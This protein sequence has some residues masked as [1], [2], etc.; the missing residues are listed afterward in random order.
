MHMGKMLQWIIAVPLA[1][2]LAACSDEP[3][4]LRDAAP[5]P[6]RGVSTNPDT[7]E[8]RWIPGQYVIVFKHHEVRNVPALARSLASA[9]TDSILYVYQHTIKGFAARLAPAAAEA[10]KRHPLVESVLQD[11]LGT[12]DQMAWSWGH[13]R[14]DQ[15]D[16]PLNGVYAPNRTGAGV[17]IYILDTGI[18]RTHIDFG[19]RA[20][21]GYS[22]INDGRGS[23]D[24]N[25]HGTHVAGT[26][27]ATSYGVAKQAAVYAVRI[28][29]CN[30]FSSVSAGISGMDWIAANRVLPAVANLSY[31]WSLRS[32][33]DDAARRLINAGV[34]LA[35]S[36]GNNNLD[37]CNYSPKRVSTAIVVGNSD[38]NDTRAFNS[39]W[40]PCVHVFAPGQ[41]IP[42]TYY[43][44]DTD[45]DVRNGT[46]MSSP[47]VAGIAALYL[48]SDPSAPAWKVKDAVL[49]SASMGKI[50][51]TQGSANRLL[52]AFPI[53]FAASV[54]GPSAIPSSGSYT[55][56]ATTEGGDGSYTY[57]W[58]LVNHL[59]GF[60]QVL[61]TG[62]TQTLSVI[63]GDGDFTI[64]VIS[65]SAGQTHRA[66]R[67]VSN[68]PTICDPSAFGCQ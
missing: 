65:S 59:H 43:R 35:T 39:N 27:A 21:H 12:P 68:A 23:D 40:G 29:D 60:E 22:A 38:E 19:G 16:R 45:T 14:I 37:A 8:R 67:Y 30:G 55:W 2:S 50:Q 53:Y 4:A 63:R 31:S 6:V 41:N 62:N 47:H 48:Q 15:R 54:D 18:R 32:D 49:N 20:H 51:D 64:T 36:A 61:G 46:S 28:A 34:T 33:I 25:G 5:V 24:C 17:N 9:P 10:L 1:A 11:E 42:S 58:S 26:A 44:N 56:T 57:Q 7:V 13:D 66:S 3:T 52:Y